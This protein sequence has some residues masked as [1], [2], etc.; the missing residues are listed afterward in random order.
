VKKLTKLETLLTTS[1]VAVV[2][3]LLLG[4]DGCTEQDKAQMNATDLAQ[5]RGNIYVM[6]NDTEFKNY[7]KRQEIADDP[8]TILWCT[9]AFPI[10]SSPLVTVPVVGKLTSGGKRPFTI[11]DTSPGPDGM[12]GSS[13]EYRYGFAPGDVYSDFYDIATYCTNKPMVWQREKT[14]IVSGVDANLLA[15]QAAAQAA[16]KA[17]HPEEATRILDEAIKGAK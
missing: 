9:F 2:S 13:G 14:S 8:T 17:G 11:S 10:P 12:Y 3:V 5:N 6:K 16:L 4:A 15:A 1:L 7:N